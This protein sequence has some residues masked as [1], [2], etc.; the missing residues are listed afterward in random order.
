MIVIVNWTRQWVI[1]FITSWPW[2]FESRKRWALSL[3]PSW[4]PEPE[5]EP[6]PEPLNLSNQS[7]RAVVRSQSSKRDASLLPCNHQRC[8]CD[9]NK[10]SR[11]GMPAQE[12][13][14]HI[15]PP[16]AWTTDPAAAA[17]TWRHSLPAIATATRLRF[18]SSDM[19]GGRKLD[20]SARSL[21]LDWAWCYIWI[22]MA[23]KHYISYIYEWHS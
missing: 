8:E 13:D 7:S 9:A 4:A 15:A 18:T 2:L 1:S 6:E 16:V 11:T 19:T 20:Q 10:Y 23:S 17:A 12:R 5:P 3:E 14:F 21:E 22:M